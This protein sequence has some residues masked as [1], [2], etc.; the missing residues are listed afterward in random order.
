PLDV[1]AQIRKIIPR[2]GQTFQ[3]AWVGIGDSVLLRIGGVDVIVCS[4]RQQTFDPSILTQF[5]VD[6]ESLELIIV[7]STQHFYRGFA[8]IARKILYVA[9][10]G[11]NY[12]DFAQIAYRRKRGPYWPAVDDPF[13]EPPP[14]APA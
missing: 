1:E 5:G 13:S 4:L 6:P 14:S 12:P 3:G 8:G 7:K 10:P 9:A 2:A 11:A